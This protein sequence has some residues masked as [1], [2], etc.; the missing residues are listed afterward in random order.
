MPARWTTSNSS[1]YRLRSHLVSLVV[2]SSIFIIHLRTYW[3][4][5]IVK[6]R[7]CM[8]DIRINT[9]QI[10]NT[11]SRCVV[12]KNVST[13]LSDLYQYPIGL[14]I[15]SGYSWRRTHPTLLSQPSVLMIYL[16]LSFRSANTASS[17]TFLVGKSFPCSQRFLKRQITQAVPCLV[18]NWA[19][20][21]YWKV[22]Y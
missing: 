13:L 10:T 2:A 3:S 1:S 19:G 6:H 9:A 11:Y 22:L 18:S 8:Y 17:Y 20:P 7:P 15:Q 21:L 14:F 4:A 5:Q 16:P 12:S